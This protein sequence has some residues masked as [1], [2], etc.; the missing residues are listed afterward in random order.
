MSDAKNMTIKYVGNK[1]RKVNRIGNLQHIIN[2]E[3]TDKPRAI[4]SL[5]S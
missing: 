1:G 5:P 3:V 2:R 4:Q